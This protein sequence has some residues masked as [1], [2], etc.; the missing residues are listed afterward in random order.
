MIG[1]IEKIIE[2]KLCGSVVYGKGTGSIISIGFGDKIKRKVPLRNDQL[3][4]ES[5]NY[6][7]ELELII[8]CCW[9]IRTSDSIILGWRDALCDDKMKEI[10]TLSKRKVT[11]VKIDP[12]TYDI[13]I[14]F[15]GD[16]FLEIMCDIT[17]DFDSDDNYIFYT[18][19]NTYAVGINSSYLK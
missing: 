11:G 16:L 13:K 5:K 2:N 10:N 15:S 8:Y 6:T 4:E 7:F 3:T 17:N 18:K 9:R 12:S 19:S 14:E 1:E